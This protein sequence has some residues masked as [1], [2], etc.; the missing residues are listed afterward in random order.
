MG[1]D[2]P[3]LPPWGSRG[4]RVPHSQQNPKIKSTICGKVRGA[5]LRRKEMLVIDYLSLDESN[6]KGVRAEPKK[7][8][9]KPVS[10]HLVN[11]S[12][13]IEI[14]KP[15][16][17]S[18]RRLVVPIPIPL[19]PPLIFSSLFPFIKGAHNHLLEHPP[20]FP[21]LSLSLSRVP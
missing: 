15:R 10:Q 21:G 19:L 9:T 7:R 3:K 6:A 12:M 16:P 13:H 2:K 18:I 4:P 20:L 17:R 8:V 1:L 11:Q 14:L 5:Q